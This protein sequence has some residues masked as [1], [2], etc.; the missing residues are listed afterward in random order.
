MF[1]V[2]A[3]PTRTYVPGG[4]VDEI[5]YQFVQASGAHLDQHYDAHGHC[6]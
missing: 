1:S 4:R 2:F 5:V 3:S 6:E